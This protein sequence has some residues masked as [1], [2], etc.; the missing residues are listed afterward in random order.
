MKIGSKL[1]ALLLVM[2]LGASS[3]LLYVLFVSSGSSVKYRQ[4]IKITQHTVLTE[5]LGFFTETGLD[6]GASNIVLDGAGHKIIGMGDGREQWGIRID[7]QT[8]VT[9]KNVEVYGFRINL[10]ITGSYNCKILNSYFHH[11]VPDHRA[12]EGWY[13]IESKDSY[14]NLFMNNTIDYISDEGIH[15]SGSLGNEIFVNNTIRSCQKEGVYLLESVGVKVLNNR[16]MNNSPG[17]YCKSSNNVIGNNTLIS[18]GIQIRYDYAFGNEIVG[19]LIFGGV[20][21]LEEGTSKN[22]VHKNEVHS[23]S[24]GIYL[25]GAENNTVYDNRIVIEGTGT[26][27][28]RIGEKDIYGS[29]GNNLY[30]NMITGNATYGIYIS[31]GSSLNNEVHHN[32]V[33]TTGNYGIYINNDALNNTIHHNIVRNHAL[34]DVYDWSKGIKNTWYNNEY[35]KR[36]W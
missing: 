20:I 16:L 12:Q 17:V 27:G 25:Y 18:N 9:I 19:N 21:R 24:V 1:L 23:S 34:Y 33:A 2:A 13:G 11:N 6:I 5:D 7:G 14:D 22:T 3:F 10:R 8:N 36:N 30:Q 31:N 4:T 15:F 28:I 29:A 26:Y 32:I 35:D